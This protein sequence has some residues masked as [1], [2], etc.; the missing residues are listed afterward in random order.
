M[1]TRFIIGAFAALMILI[2]LI[3]WVLRGGL[4][5]PSGP[6]SPPTG[7]TLPTISDQGVSTRSAYP[8]ATPVPVTQVRTYANQ[9]LALTFS[10]PKNYEI[11]PI[12]KGAT[13]SFP[14]LAYEFIFKVAQL[15]NDFS[16]GV[17]VAP[18]PEAKSLTDILNEEN[19]DAKINGQ[20]P[21]TFTVINPLGNSQ[22]SA[23]FTS[24][25]PSLYALRTKAAVYYVYP[26]QPNPLIDAIV[27]SFMF[28][29]GK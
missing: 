11:T 28:S 22:E 21:A 1:T 19:E 5:Q 7:G 18:H 6:K 29:A 14:F 27:A 16:F 13:A 25:S 9:E 10:Y 15:G 24:D 23:K 8:L 17:F 26:I 12:R 4:F 20:T 3:F 2:L